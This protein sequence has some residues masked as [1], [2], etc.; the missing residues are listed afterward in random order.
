MMVCGA[1]IHQGVKDDPQ[2]AA[3]SGRR[4]FKKDTIAHRGE[5]LRSVGHPPPARVQSLSKASARVMP[6]GWRN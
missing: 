3:T 5:V 1:G 4:W 6:P 2:V